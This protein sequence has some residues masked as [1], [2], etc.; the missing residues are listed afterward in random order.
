MSERLILQAV[1]DGNSMNVKTNGSVIEC[2][3]AIG[4][5]IE[6]LYYDQ[7]SKGYNAED[8]MRAMCEILED[9]ENRAFRLARERY[10]KEHGGRQ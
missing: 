1:D 5:A 6:A 8:S 9:I 2:Y 7:L 10:K 4:C 3:F